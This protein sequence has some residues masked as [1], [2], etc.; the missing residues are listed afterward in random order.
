MAKLS[1]IAAIA[2]SRMSKDNIVPRNE[3]A[4]LLKNWA[5]HFKTFK[6]GWNENK[7]PYFYIGDTYANNG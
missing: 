2:I 3:E 4:Y 5:N 7:Q 6:V 1:L